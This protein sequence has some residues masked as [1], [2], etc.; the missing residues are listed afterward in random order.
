MSLAQVH[1]TS[2][3]P[4]DDGTRGRFTAV[5]PGI[6]SALLAEIEPLLG[7]EAPEDAP[8]LPTDAELRSLPEA[9]TYTLLADGGRM[10]S[11]TVP[12]RSDGS[13]PPRFHSHAVFVPAGGQLPGDRLPI[14]AWRSPRWVAVTPGGAIP[15]PLGGTH[16]AL[17]LER[18]AL[19]DFAVSRG[20]WLTGVFADL[21]R[22]CAGS[23]GGPSGGSSGGGEQ[24]VLVERQSADVARWLGLA[25]SALPPE[26][27][28]RLTFTTYTRSPRTAPQRV[29]GVL[30]RDAEGLAEAGLHV[31]VC[32]GPRSRP[33]SGPGDAWAET[34]ALVW[35]NRAPELFAE[36][37]K[38]HG[39][40]FAAG[41]LAVTALGAG[42]ALGSAERAAAA[43][44]AAERPYALDAKQTARLVDALTAPGPGDR[45]RDE[46]DAVGRLFGALDGRAPASVTAPLAAMLATEAVRGGNDSLELPGRDAFDGPE[47]RAV[48]E[49]LGPEIRTELS[50]PA[51]RPEVARTIQLLRVAKLLDVD[52]A[53]LLPDAIRRL[54]PAM[55]GGDA[56]PD[57]GPALLELLYEQFDV[58]TALL[59]ALDE[60][61]PTE[62]VR[63]AALLRQVELPFTG[64]QSLPHLRMCAASAEAR[65]S[66]GED[67]AA[68]LHRVLRAAGLSPFAEPLVLRTAVGLVWDDRAPTAGEARLV[69]E[70]ATSDTHRAAGT[71]SRLVDAALA[72]PADDE[73]ATELAHEVLQGFPQQIGGRVRSALLLLDFA[74]TMGSSA[75]VSAEGGDRGGDPAAE[76]GE[77][78]SAASGWAEYVRSLASR[79]E[80]LEAA[81][82]EHAYGALARRLLT[83]GR[84]EA[85]MY[86]FVHTDDPGLLA[87]YAR[88]AR[89]AAVGER[90]RVDAGFTA[91]CYLTWSTHPHAGDHWTRTASALLEDV[92]RPAVRALPAESLAAVEAAIE[93][94][95]SSGRTESFRAWNR[96]PSPLGRLGRR[97]AGRVRRG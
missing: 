63:V 54:A 72:A 5:A 39:E 30:P 49:A 77:P 33:L 43:R 73:D 60:L 17:G 27:A 10:V 69:L 86:A 68:A 75:S 12:V 96:R 52:C 41:P 87:A 65:A 24:V 88:E 92:L 26:H 15:D 90:L 94:A 28:E 81:V 76:T 58:R 16:A 2:A 62:P 85:E 11:R 22:A 29:L 3:A 8:F 84:P 35:R 38:L 97:I 19:G 89:E 67:R 9:F 53:D 80:P 56:E 20:P 23:S 95:G 13:G 34:A 31:H 59:V 45:N 37:R 46:F 6:S 51:S 40:P 61:A 7:Y 44:W 78:P 18:E 48:A 82:R 42:I 55:L 74:R 71:W 66:C 21:R 93:Q 79:A 14:T 50:G 36:A 83:P 70:A 91:D 47:G 1:Y 32:T 4:G 64:S 25:A 57:W